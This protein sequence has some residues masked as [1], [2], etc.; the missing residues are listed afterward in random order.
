MASALRCSHLNRALYFLRGF[1]YSVRTRAYFEEIDFHIKQELLNA[2]ESVKVCVAWISWRKYTS[3]FNQ[4][5]KK[6]VKVEVIYN[7]DFI[8][9]KNFHS[10][11]PET[12]LYPVK[13]RSSALMH[14]KFCIIDKQ[15]LLTGSFNWSRNARRHFE[16][17]VI[18]DHDYKLI[19]GFL[20]EFE[21][22]KNYYSDYANQ[23]RVNC[24]H[25][26]DDYRLCR[27]SAYNLG[28]LGHESGLY[29][30]SVIELWNV[31]LR[32]EHGTFI[33]EFHEQHLQSYL[34]LKDAPEYDNGYH[35]DKSDMLEEFEQEL[36]Q[37]EEVHNYF[38]NRGGEPVHAIGIVA[39]QNEHLEYS[40][41]PEYVVNIIW[42]DMY[43]RKVIPDVLYDD[44]YGFVNQIIMNQI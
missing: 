31:C 34:G 44:S 5:T 13:A 20:T 35:Y 11:F 4:L 2:R 7:D 9:K 21:D 17:I 14:N 3:I 24:L 27:S 32:N 1:M 36:R 19:K 42:R 15:T 22:L 37:T 40:V 39:M 29:D 6:G 12:K 8:N 43:Y 28:I 30:D 41:D 10:P 26:H 16:N 33:R 25:E 23:T 18:I 38:V